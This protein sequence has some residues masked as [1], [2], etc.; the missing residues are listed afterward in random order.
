MVSAKNLLALRVIML[1]GKKICLFL[2]LYS[3]FS[4]GTE[5][6]K[7]KYLNERSQNKIYYTENKGQVSDQDFK[8]RTDILFSANDGQLGYYFKKNGVSYQ[9]YK[10]NSL[11]TFKDPK[12][13]EERTTADKTEIYRLDINWLN[14][15]QNSTI[16]T[17]KKADGVN[18]YYLQ[19]CPN[20]ALNVKSYQ[21][22]KY[23]NLYDGI[24]LKWYQQ[25]G[26]IKYDYLISPGANY[27]QIQLSITGVS[28]MQLQKDGSVIL[29]TPLGDIKEAA[30]LVFQN[31]R[32][33]KAKWVIKEHT[34][35]FEI[36]NYNPALPMIIDPITRMWG[37]YFGSPSDDYFLDC[38][39]DSA[40]NVI[41][42]G[43]TSST[44]TLIVSSGAHQQTYGGGTYDALI[45]KFDRYGVRQWSTF[46]GGAFP[47]Y[48][49]SCATDIAGNVFMC[50][51][52][53]PGGAPG[54]VIATTGCHQFLS[55]GLTDAFLVKFDLN[56]VRQWGTFYGDSGFESGS[57]CAADPAGNVY[58]CGSTN[59]GAGFNIIAT[60][61]SHQ[62]VNNGSS[63]V[64]LVKFDPA[65][66][67]IYGTYYGGVGDDNASS[68]TIDVSG[69]VYIAGVTTTSVGT[70]I[71]IP[72][73]H[74]NFN[75]GGQD[76]FLVKFNTTGV[77]QWGTYYGGSAS[78]WVNACTTDASSNVYISGFTQTPSS[79]IIATAGAHQTVY[80]GGND[81]I[82]IKFNTNGVRLWGTYYGANGNERSWGCAVDTSGNICMSGFTSPYAGTV[83]ATAG[84]WQSTSGGFIDGYLAIFD[85]MGVRQWSTYY[86]GNVDDYGYGCAADKKG[87][88]YF[89]G[90]AGSNVPTT[91]FANPS[92][93]QPT[94]GGYFDGFLVRFAGCT[95]P[96]TPSNITAA[97][98]QTVCNNGSVILAAAG[99]GT[100][101]WFS[102]AVGGLSVHTGTNYTTPTLTTGASPATY[103]FYAQDQNSC[104]TSALRVPITVT[105][106][107]SPTITISG[108]SVCLGQT[109]NIAASGANTYSWSTG[110]TSTILPVSPTVNTSYSVIGTALNTCTSSAFKTITVNPLPAIIV[111]SGS[112][113]FGNTYTITPSGASTYTISGG[114]A[115]VSPTVNTSYSVTGTSSLGCVSLLPAVVNL[116]VLALPVITASSGSVCSG[117]VYTISPIGAIT[118]T[119][120]GGSALVSPTVTTNYSVTGTDINGCISQ[121]STILTVSVMVLP[122]LTLNTGAICI[123]DT[124][125]LSAL[126]ANT[127]T[128]SSGSPIVSPTTTTNYTITGTDVIGC[129]SL[130]TVTSITVN[131]LPIINITSPSSV[132]CIGQTASLTA[133]GAQN[134]TWSTASNFS[135]IN[136]S[137]TITSTYSVTGSSAAGCISTLTAMSTVSVVNMPTVS[138]NSGS[139]CA[140]TI[141]TL[142][143]S[144]AF[145][146]TYSGGSSTVA[147]VTT[148]N[149][150]VTGMTVPGCTHTAV[151]NITVH[152]LPIVTVSSGS[153]C[154]GNSFTIIPSGA[155]TYTYSSGSPVVSPA[156]SA[157]YTITGTDIIG[158]ISLPAI[159]NITV[160]NL[161]ILSV[162]SSSSLLCVGQTAS[163]TGF[164]ALTYTWST[165]ATGSVIV[166]SPTVNAI[167]TLYATDQNGCSNSSVFIQN[168]SPCTALLEKNI[169]EWIKIFPN[170]SSDKITI[171][172]SIE[173]NYIEVFDAMGKLIIYQ[174]NNVDI[175][176]SQFSFG[177]Y[178]LNVFA[179]NN[180]FFT[181][182]IIKE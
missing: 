128:Y 119:Y 151:S 177:I 36:E 19:S 92:S 5:P 142:I 127:Y 72:S 179:E 133:T 32:I 68:C 166:I 35:S 105:V 1:C 11:K 178:F 112:F 181:G 75:G 12:T 63:D 20:G 122:T 34:L 4:F 88:I 66:N 43:Y 89:C 117:S 146:Y 83:I 101:N 33:L 23:T 174:S 123:N 65:G 156:T 17:D 163:L 164:G 80:N 21:E 104:M 153:I 2:L 39:T 87:N 172:S 162:T 170:P 143:P 124:F 46:Y 136:V 78:D 154:P 144:G 6:L 15:N 71:A 149:Y 168:V 98:N 7:A 77:R 90:L 102:N 91:C 50:G 131:P 22:I 73:A 169:N 103:T 18:N 111:N 40:A 81:A 108:S 107:P 47:D 82:L 175:N 114:N 29:K 126:G 53:G 42:T 147:P 137:P 120:S 86:G 165:S 84:S 125:T 152:A 96:P 160:Y 99:T 140:G 48:A 56:G 171:S 109:L 30:P 25:D 138:V 97:S 60:P 150:T 74:Q 54:N 55:G 44:A 132:I 157:T 67:R 76:G 14:C 106:L 41:A 69:N 141:F 118:Y 167:Y 85:S 116:T 61:G 110:A 159:S 93:H 28:K 64:Y 176:L 52:T 10:T 59:G 57:A 148:T 129:I 45:V 26:Q 100:I 37:T 134:Y 173:I 135:L 13:K 161:P 51:D 27:K 62:T 182:K 8:P 115:L 70:G 121:P 79:T 158:C 113:C 24:D 130:P 145:T 139:I 58:L 38:T 16:L 155:N 9:L 95:L 3:I 180:K 49:N 94:F 31:N